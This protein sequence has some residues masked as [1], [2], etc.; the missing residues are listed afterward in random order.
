MLFLLYTGYRIGFVNTSNTLNEGVG[1]HVVCVRMFEPPDDVSISDSFV[2][3]V[4]TVA[5]TAGKFLYS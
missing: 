5:D 2:A 1:F 4:E 3:A